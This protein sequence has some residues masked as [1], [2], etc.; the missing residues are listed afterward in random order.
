MTF[1][2]AKPFEIDPGTRVVHQQPSGL[3][4]H[5]EAESSV[6]ENLGYK[7]VKLKHLRKYVSLDTV[8]V[9]HTME[10]VR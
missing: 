8:C 1:T 2:P 7:R 4:V 5:D 3:L 10:A 6:L 9:D